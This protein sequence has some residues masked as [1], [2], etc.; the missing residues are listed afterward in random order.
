MPWC[1]LV[2]RPSVIIPIT[3][4][5]WCFTGW[6][7]FRWPNLGGLKIILSQDGGSSMAICHVDSIYLPSTRKAGLNAR[8][9]IATT[10]KKP[11]NWLGDPEEWCVLIVR[12][13]WIVCGSVMEQGMSPVERLRGKSLATT[14]KQQ[15]AHL[16]ATP[17]PSP[18][19]RPVQWLFIS[20]R[21]TL[22]VT[23]PRL[24]TPR[25]ES[26]QKLI[27]EPLVF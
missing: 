16:L 5:R 6:Y 19:R 9:S 10:Y 3:I 22:G 25:K 15:G 8:H 18:F 7:Q 11:Y 23:N 1:Q 21:R 17:P 4:S 13:W 27:F 14:S 26:I 20:G 12:V 24:T 2:L